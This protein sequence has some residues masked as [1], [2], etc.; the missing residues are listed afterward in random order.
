M[1][2]YA[3]GLLSLGVRKGDAFALL[4]TTRP[5]WA[6][7]DFAL[8]SIGAIGVGIYANSSPKDTGLHPRPLGGGRDPL[9]GRRP[10][11][12]GRVRPGGDPGTRA[13]PH[14]HRPAR[15][16][17][18]GTCLRGR[19][20][21]RAA[22]GVRGDRR[23]RPLHVHL[24]VR[25]DRP[26]EGLHD[27]EPQLLRDGRGRRR[28]RVV[29]RPR[30]HD[31][32]LPAARAQL[33]PADA[34]VRAL[35]RLHDRV[36]ARPAAGRSGAARGPPDGVPERAAR[37]R[38]DPHGRRRALRRGHRPA[39]EAGR[40]GAPCRPR[41]E[42][43]APRRTAGPARAG[44]AVPRRRPARLREGQGAPGWPPAHRHLGRRPALTRDRRVL[45]R[46]RHP[47]RR[48]LRADRVHDRSVDEH[49]E[50][51]PLR[52][53]RQGAAALRGQARGGRRAARQE[54]DRLPGVLQGSRGDGGGAGRRT[55]G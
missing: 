23:G 8:G 36:P 10:A 9:R 34:P 16:R 25:H 7:F 40:L 1:E 17:G 30:R 46:D 26:A 14:V 51:L 13:R 2:E 45:P 49:A 4:A 35:R 31:A 32:A 37:L 43:A 33:R 52:H 41:R 42:R 12:E 27:L 48:G 20:S 22:R 21:G 19:S 15:A 24:H 54:R 3:N 44:G 39:P 11:R 28:S 50:R 5:E 18:A 53:R 55:A 29:H 47:P 38:E 6:L